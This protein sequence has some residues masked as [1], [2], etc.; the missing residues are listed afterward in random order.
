[1]PALLQ[2]D[3][4]IVSSREGVLAIA[5]SV[6]GAQPRSAPNVALSC[7]AETKRSSGERST[8]APSYPV[9]GMM[10]ACDA[11]TCSASELQ[12]CAAVSLARRLELPVFAGR[13]KKSPPGSDIASVS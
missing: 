2:N 7:H 1:M 11:V 13:R 8:T 5:P 3:W 4:V 9:S 12:P 6:E 10:R